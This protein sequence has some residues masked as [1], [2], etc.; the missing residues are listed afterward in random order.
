[1]IAVRRERDR[2]GGVR[3]ARLDERERRQRAGRRVMQER[4]GHR[5]EPGGT[6]VPQSESSNV[7]TLR[8]GVCPER[9]AHSATYGMVIMPME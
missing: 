6:L 8:F 5:P 1:M 3:V 2:R 4:R 9:A 7:A